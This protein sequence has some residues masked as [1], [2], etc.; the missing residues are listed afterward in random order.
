[1]SEADIMLVGEKIPEDIGRVFA[2]TGSSGAISLPHQLVTMVL[3]DYRL[4]DEEAFQ[5]PASF[6]VALCKSFLLISP[7][8]PNFN[9]DIVWSPLIAKLN[10]EPEL[11]RPSPTD[12]M[13]FN[14]VLADGQQVIRSIR[15]ATI[16]PEC[17]QALW[18]A[19]QTLMA[20]EFTGEELQHEMI[21][22]FSQYPKGIPETFFHESC[23]LGD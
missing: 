19:Q 13:V 5:A 22:L 7:S 9:F 8:F 11:P 4:S 15:T 21:A 16:S 12:H 1:M 23:L 6:R 18:R 3:H 14:F 10:G 17:G 20:A 2:L